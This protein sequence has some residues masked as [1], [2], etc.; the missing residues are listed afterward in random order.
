MGCLTSKPT[1]VL[2]AARRDN[3][4]GGLGATGGAAACRARG[5]ADAWH[6]GMCVMASERDS[7][8]ASARLSAKHTQDGC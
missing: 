4:E 3:A 5:A 2:H 1:A 8:F 6:V 7:V